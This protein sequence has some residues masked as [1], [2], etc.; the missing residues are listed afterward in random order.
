MGFP[1]RILTMTNKTIPFTVPLLDLQAQYAPYE[2]LV[3]QKVTEVIKSKQFI[4]GDL[5]PQFESLVTTYAKV[6]YALTMSS[7]TDALLAAL[8]A[9]DVQP[10]D[11]V[12]TT[13]F[14]FFA[15]A[16]SIARLGAKPVFVDIDPQTFNIDVNQIDSKITSK[17]KAIMPVHL[18][19]Q[20]SDMDM[21]MAIAKKHQLTVI[22][23]A[24]Q[25]LGAFYYSENGQKMA[26]SIGHMG[27]YSFFPSKNLGC[28]GDGGMTV[29]SDVQL[30]QKLKSIR[31]HGE[32]TRYHHQY[33]GANFRLDTIQAAVLLVKFP[34]LDEQ[35]K[36]RQKN[37]AYYDLALKDLV[38]TPI[39]TLKTPSIYN[40]Y[41]IRTPK[42][43]ALQKHLTDRGIGTGIY[44]PRPMH[45][46]ECFSYLG[47][48][49]GD[50]PESEKAAS[51]ILALPIYAELNN[52]QL[53]YIVEQ[54]RSFFKN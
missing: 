51:E 31:T 12:I 36:G 33:I 41:C 2:E 25:S 24:A 1:K 17:T 4:L 5:L 23:D 34:Y 37:A 39:T 40:Q 13:P 19:G 53:S 21:I 6:S 45:L 48:R 18:F 15:T 22:E 27:T 9:I 46:Q 10:G 50:F 35:N 11:E 20:V 49:M 7:G 14:T 3:I 42:R 8:M 29:T 54:I 26:G 47:Y 52:T 38:Q 43:D 30:H 32:V 16:G 44:Y 28:A